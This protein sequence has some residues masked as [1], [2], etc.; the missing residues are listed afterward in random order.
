MNIAKMKKAPLILIS[1]ST[2]TRGAEFSRPVAQVEAEARKLAAA[3]VRELTLLGQN[4][5][6]YH[7]AS[8]DGP[9]P[10]GRLLTR[11][12][13]IDGITRLRFMTSHPRDMDDELIAALASNPSPARTS[14]VCCPRS[15]AGALIS[16]GVSESCQGNPVTWVS[17]AV[18]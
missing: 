11:L 2:Q 5:N 16:G 14:S 1:P 3:G 9:C 6:A 4:V 8:P 7:G 10:L 15:G 12:S 17:P 13:Q 18:G